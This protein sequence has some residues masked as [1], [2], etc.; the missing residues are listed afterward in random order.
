M[1]VQRTGSVR[2]YE[3]ITEISL[4]AG[5]T[6]QLP[7][8]YIWRPINS[9]SGV[10]PEKPTAARI[11]KKFSVF[12]GI[13]RFIIVFAKARQ[14]TISSGRN[15]HLRAMWSVLPLMPR[16]PCGIFLYDISGSQGGDYLDGCLL[17][18]Y[19]GPDDGG[20]KHRWN[21]RTLLTDCAAHVNK[22]K[23]IE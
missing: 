5:Y 19:D 23:L 15:R 10:F 17:G 12:Y 1:A 16:S 22:L 9:W 18:C 6:I 13:R 20:S 3:V 4:R 21:V 8:L 14:K 11:T 7:I 2:A